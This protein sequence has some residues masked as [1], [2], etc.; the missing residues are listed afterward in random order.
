M[1]CGQADEAPVG[2]P[3]T[4]ALAGASEF[5]PDCRAERVMIGGRSGVVVHHPDGGFRRLAIA[6]G[7][8]SIE[9]LD[10]A[11]EARSALKGDRYEVIVGTDRYVIPVA[12]N[13]AAR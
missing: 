1:A 4:C 10:G 9:P 5:T 2:E 6:A 3:I 7:G 12:G 11:D 13:A 8:Q